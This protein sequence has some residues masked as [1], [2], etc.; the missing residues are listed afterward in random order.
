[1]KLKKFLTGESA[2]NLRF[3]RKS[4]T[5]ELIKSLRFGRRIVKNVNE[6]HKNKINTNNLIVT[7]DN[8]FVI[9]SKQLYTENID[10]VF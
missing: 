4:K 8:I 10:D 5:A 3:I 9:Q 6:H 7:K 1:M 2:V